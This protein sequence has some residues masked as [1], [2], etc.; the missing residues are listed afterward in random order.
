MEKEVKKKTNNVKKNTNKK[1]NNKKLKD[2]KTKINAKKQEE[3]KLEQKR[4]EEKKIA[5]TNSTTSIILVIIIVILCFVCVLGSLDLE[6]RN[7]DKYREYIINDNL[8]DENNII[9][10]MKQIKEETLTIDDLD[11]KLAYYGVAY[12]FDEDEE[13]VYDIKYTLTCEDVIIKNLTYYNEVQGVNSIQE[14]VN[15]INGSAKSFIKVL[16]NEDGEKSLVLESYSGVEDVFTLNIYNLANGKELGE[17]VFGYPQYILDISKYKLTD[18]F[19]NNERYNIKDGQIIE[20]VKYD[21]DE[22]KL[23][24]TDV[25]LFNDNLDIDNKALINNFGDDGVYFEV[26]ERLK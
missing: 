6:N 1:N 9:V 10:D 8:R 15:V 11:I 22:N 2:N 7:K 23:L 26:N 18:Y 12:K 3:K 24:L 17:F 16:K 25:T 21:E 13:E 5:T 14:L 20:Y 4:L 19:I